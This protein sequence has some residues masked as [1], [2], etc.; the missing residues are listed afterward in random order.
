MY[1]SNDAAYNPLMGSGE[2]AAA[3]R[4]A[5]VESLRDNTSCIEISPDPT[6]HA[7]KKKNR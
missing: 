6:V 4:T 2:R 1:C 3:A 5:K 7:S